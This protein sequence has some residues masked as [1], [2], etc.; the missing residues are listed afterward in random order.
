MYVLYEIL[1]ML[2][3]IGHCIL[4]SEYNICDKSQK[5]AGQ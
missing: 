4:M 3:I 1:I 5:E 2:L